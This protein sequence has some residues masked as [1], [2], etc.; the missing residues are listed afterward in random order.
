[1]N[2]AKRF[3]LT[4][5]A[6]ALMTTPAQAGFK[7]YFKGSPNVAAE[8][9][10]TPRGPAGYMGVPAAPGNLSAPAPSNNYG[11]GVPN[12]IVTFLHPYT[13]QAVT[14]PLTLPVGKPTITTRTDRIIYNYGLLSPKVVIKFLPAGG[15]EVRYN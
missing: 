2:T 15:V 14:V 8:S 7:I 5:A 9:A 13:N 1:M 3:L 6:V 10:V 12:Q 11:A 4:A